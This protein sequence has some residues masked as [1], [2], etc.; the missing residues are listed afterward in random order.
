MTDHGP[1]LVTEG[2]AP[3]RQEDGQIGFVEVDADVG[4]EETNEPVLLT[5]TPTSPNIGLISTR[6]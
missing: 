6:G 5:N 4:T 2:P 1:F 3:S